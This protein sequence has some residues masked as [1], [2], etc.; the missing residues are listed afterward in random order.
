MYI[1][2]YKVQNDKWLATMYPISLLVLQVF[3]FSTDQAESLSV[4]K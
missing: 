3:I 2:V 4:D 1:H